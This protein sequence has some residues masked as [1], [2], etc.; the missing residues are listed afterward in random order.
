MTFESILKIYTPTDQKKKKQPKNQSYHLTFLNVLQSNVSWHKDKVW[1]LVQRRLGQELCRILANMTEYVQEVATAT[2]KEE[3]FSIKSTHFF[4][5]SLGN[6]PLCL[7]EDKIAL[8]Q[9][10]H[11]RIREI[12]DW[13]TNKYT[14]PLIQIVTKG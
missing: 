2:K 8:P 6:C 12:D 5:S 3:N 11:V 4:I 9:G 14:P 7:G 1:Y 10:E 13:E